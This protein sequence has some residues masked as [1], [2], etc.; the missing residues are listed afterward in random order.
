MAVSW[1]IGTSPNAELVNTM[2]EDAIDTL[3]DSEH[4]IVHSD[5]F[6]YVNMLITVIKCTIN[7]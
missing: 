4:P 6:V 1:N 2:L 5:I 3:S 7:H